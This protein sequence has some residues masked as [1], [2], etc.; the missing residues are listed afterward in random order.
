MS[1]Y[2]D[3]I[4]LAPKSPKPKKSKPKK[5]VKKVK[6]PIKK[7]P[8]KTKD[9]NPKSIDVVLN[10]S[11]ADPIVQPTVVITPPVVPVFVAP[12]KEP[13]YIKHLITCR[14]HL[15]QYEQMDPIPSHKF[16]VFSELDENDMFKHSYAQCNN[17]GI[18]HRVTELETSYTIKKESLMALPNIEDIKTTVPEWLIGILSQ[19]Q[20]ELHVWQE[21]KF[22]IDNGLWG[23]FV[24]LTKERDSTI[25]FG[26]ALHIIGTK[27]YKIEN[28]ERNDDDL[29]PY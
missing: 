25:V 5:L 17:C 26:K 28:F 20:C 23:R 22:I 21:A 24:V 9:D 16:V 12:K 18:I 1:I 2:D 7:Q 19:Y 4:E 10:N 11:V 3:D 15:P 27:L 13:D 14:C 8:A 29:K 6:A